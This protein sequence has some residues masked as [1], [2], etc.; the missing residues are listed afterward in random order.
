MR[1]HM[2]GIGGVGMSSLALY[3]NYLGYEVRGS[4]DVQNSRT[5]LLR[6]KG[7]EVMIGH[8][9]ENVGKDVSLVITSSA[10]FESNVE[11]LEARRRRIRVMKRMEVLNEIINTKYKSIGVTGTHGKTTTT[12]MIGKILIDAGYDPTVSIG[13]ELEAFG[14]NIRIGKDTFFVSEVDE[15]D[16]YFRQTCPAVSVITNVDRDHL[17]HYEEDMKRLID[18]FK[19]YAANARDFTVLTLPDCVNIDEKGV[20]ELITCSTSDP[21]VDYYSDELH[22]EDLGSSFNVYERGKRSVKLFLPIPG[23]HNINDALNAIAVCRRLGVDFTTIKNSLKTFKGVK[24]RFDVLYRNNRHNIYVVDDYAHHP[25]QIEKNL[26]TIRKIFRG[27]VVVIFQPH[28]YTRLVRENGNFTK[29]LMKADKVYVTDVYAA[30]EKMIDG[31]DSKM[32]VTSL[33][34]NDKDAIYVSDFDE[35]E[36]A[37]LNNE[38]KDNT[39]LITFGAGDITEVTKKVSYELKCKKD[40]PR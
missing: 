19:R 29:A 20:K 21:S 38:V 40:H 11:L 6:K 35:L 26:L 36:Y 16:G 28:R 2:I 13:G 12:A 39:F 23:I 25:T 15:S 9:F 4:N 30:S 31:I 8:R 34:R 7:I 37:I 14:G 17:E 1:V 24:R 27:R 18:S 33:K 22:I 10:I 5:L 3:L 32:I